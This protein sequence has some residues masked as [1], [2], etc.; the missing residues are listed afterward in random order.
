MAYKAIHPNETFEYISPNDPDKDNPTAWILGTLD[1]YTLS[2]LRDI[3][4]TSSMQ[5]KEQTNPLRLGTFMREI[6]KF[7]LKG[8]KNFLDS[9]GKE[10]EYHQDVINSWGRSYQVVS[11][12]LLDLISQDV[13][14]ELS[15]A[16]YKGNQLTQ[17]ERKN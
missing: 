12:K 8:W 2:K 10:I 15:D 3:I 13:L 14:A 9:E 6:V 11:E 17:E 4:V 16:I 5:N 1:S 7:G